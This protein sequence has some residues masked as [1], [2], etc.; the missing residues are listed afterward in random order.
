MRGYYALFSCDDWKSHSS[1]VLIGV[2]NQTELKKQVRKR[3]KNETFNI[4]VN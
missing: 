1:F 3:V 4:I 2:F